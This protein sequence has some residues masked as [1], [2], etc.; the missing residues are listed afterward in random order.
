M[1]TCK[2]CGREYAD[3]TRGLCRRCW[4][5][6]DIREQYPMMVNRRRS[7]EHTPED[8][9]MEEIEATIAERLPTMPQDDHERAYSYMRDDLP[10]CVALGR[11][12]K[13]SYRR[14]V[15]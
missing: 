10:R 9:T 15:R 1:T 2:H 7:S 8:A 13:S 3:L 4:L 12:V 14:E 6:M 11:G 5:Q